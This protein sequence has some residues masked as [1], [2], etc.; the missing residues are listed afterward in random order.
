MLSLGSLRRNGGQLE[1]HAG[2]QRHDSG[3]SEDGEY[4]R[5]VMQV[6]SEPIEI[7]DFG[8]YPRNVGG[9]TRDPPAQL[10][11]TAETKVRRQ[12]RLLSAHGQISQGGTVGPMASAGGKAACKIPDTP[13]NEH[14]GTNLGRHP[15]SQAQVEYSAPAGRRA[16]E[17][18]GNQASR[19][20]QR[21]Y[22]CQAS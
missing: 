4:G 20:G 22:R 14:P 12:A 5:R 10:L 21:H 2:F 3:R 11:P 16:V 18:N 8:S 13:A 17:G 19:V 15:G 1:T 7:G 6:A 9:G